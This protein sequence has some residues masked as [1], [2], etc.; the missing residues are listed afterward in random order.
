M[1]ADHH[2]YYAFA[3]GRWEGTARL[4]ITSWRALLQAPLSWLERW[5]N[6]SL[7]LADRLFGPVP[8]TTAILPTDDP[9]TYHHT[10]VLTLFGV[11]LYEG[12][13]TFTL[14]ADGHSVHITGT[15]ARWPFLG[16][17][18]PLPPGEAS[19]QSDVRAHYV[20]HT[21][22]QRWAVDMTIGPQVATSTLV[23]PWGQG[24]EDLV[25]ATAGS[26]QGRTA[27]TLGA[28]EV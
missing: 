24:R 6:V 9:D 3:T 2:G 4:R 19:I 13:R 20:L 22:G 25:R 18:R 11:R 1:P 17:H 23:C 12:R 10:A 16:T 27:G 5:D 7:A 21:T 26:R 8:L 14:R 15:E 28:T